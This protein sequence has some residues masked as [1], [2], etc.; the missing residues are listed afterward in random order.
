MMLLKLPKK[1]VSLGLVGILS[2]GVL[3]STS[4]AAT[5]SKTVKNNFSKAWELYASGDSGRASLTYGYNTLLI[6]ED[7]AYANHSTKNHHASLTNGRGGFTGPNK[8]KGNLS[9]IEVRHSGSTV[10][11]KC[12]Y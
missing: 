5:L 10:T 6:N 3:V 11:Y 4:S 8:S 7:Y 1:I 2:L 12:N 9:K